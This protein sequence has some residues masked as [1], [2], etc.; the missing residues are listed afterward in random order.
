MSGDVDQYHSVAIWSNKT[1]QQSN[2][3]LNGVWD[4]YPLPC[5]REKEGLLQLVV[6]TIGRNI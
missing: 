3:C 1:N 4:S 2:L 6:D 5:I